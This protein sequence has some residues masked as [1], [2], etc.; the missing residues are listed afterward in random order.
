MFNHM[1][2]EQES[3]GPSSPRSL[4]AAPPIDPQAEVAAYESLWLGDG[5]W[6]KTLAELFHRNPG[7]VPSELV[8]SK[9]VAETWAALV[10]FLGK[11]RI[12]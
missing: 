12:R 6:F 4:F 11:D 7:A 2:H 3:A 10:A 8:P 1:T 5:T 9:T